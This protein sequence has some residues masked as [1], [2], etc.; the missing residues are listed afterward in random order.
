MADITDV[1]KQN[2][3]S[4]AHLEH[5]LDR[6]SP[7]DFERSLGAGWTITAALGHLTF[8]DAKA[9]ATIR[10]HIETGAPLDRSGVS[11]LEDSDDIVNDAVSVLASAADPDRMRAAVVRAAN[12]I[13]E[14]LQDTDPDLL[15]PVLDGPHA[16]LV[17]RGIH[18]EEHVEQIAGVLG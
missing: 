17:Q 4:L 9:L 6:L 11:A 18:R 8:W 15:Q 14:F 3:T 12:A 1:L 2:A 16:Y 10:H 5:V 13:D 7:E